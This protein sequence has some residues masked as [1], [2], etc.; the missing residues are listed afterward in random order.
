MKK[1]LAFSIIFVLLT[2]ALV[3]QTKNDSIEIRKYFF[4]LGIRLKHDGKKIKTMRQMT[5]IMRP[6]PDATAYLKKA[7]LTRA[8]GLSLCLGAIAYIDAYNIYW[9]RTSRNMAT[10]PNMNPN[11]PYIALGIVALS[12]PFNLSAG[13]NMKRAIK[14]YNAGVR[15][16]AYNGLTPEY[17]LSVSVTSMGLT[18]KFRS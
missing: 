11:V 14:V 3:A 15:K 18:I 13:H 12:I 10:T 6:N 1:L 4:G 16:T 7:K 5:N 9:I 8:I 2:H 17:Y